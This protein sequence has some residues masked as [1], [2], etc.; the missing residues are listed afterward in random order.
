MLAQECGV[1]EE[2]KQAR[3]FSRSALAI[4][5]CARRFSKRQKKKVCAQTTRF[6]FLKIL[7]KVPFL[8]NRVSC[9]QKEK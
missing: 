9:E 4:A 7:L 1:R 2:G 6:L 8:K 3:L 5:R